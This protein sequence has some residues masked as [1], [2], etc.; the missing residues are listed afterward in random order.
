MIIDV[1]ILHTTPVIVVIVRVIDV[2]YTYISDQ[3]LLHT[4]PVIVITTHYTRCLCLL[5]TTSVI[6]VLLH[7]TSVIVVIDSLL[8]T[9]HQLSL[10]VYHWSLLHTTSLI[11]II[12]VYIST[13]HYYTTTH[14]ISDSSHWY[15]ITTHYISDSLLHTTSVIDVYYTLH[16]W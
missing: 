11:V 7:H 10:I 12:D 2:Y 5:H 4:T 8:H 16:Q 6:V 1:V 15:H 13:T 14:Y 9:T 3:Y